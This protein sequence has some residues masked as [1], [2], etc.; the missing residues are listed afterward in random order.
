MKK[1]NFIFSVISIILLLFSLLIYIQ[2]RNNIVFFNWLDIFISNNNIIIHNKIHSYIVFSLPV[3]LFLLSIM[4]FLN[5]L[6]KKRKEKYCYFIIILIILLTH[7]IL[8]KTNNIYGTYDLLDI[9][10][11]ITFF[12]FGLLVNLVLENKWKNI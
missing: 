3:G 12:I 8:Q 2:H 1:T 10:T 4:I 5:L 7:E 11:I 9:L 6:W